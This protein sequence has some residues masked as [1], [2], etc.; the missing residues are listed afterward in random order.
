MPG[1]SNHHVLENCLWKAGKQDSITTQKHQ[2]DHSLH[3]VGTG[4]ESN[5]SSQ[6][7]KE[8]KTTINISMVEWG[9]AEVISAWGCSRSLLC[10]VGQEHSA[11]SVWAGRWVFT[12]NKRQLKV[13]P[14][15]WGDT[16]KA[17]S[18]QSSPSTAGAQCLVHKAGQPLT[19]LHNTSHSE[20]KLVGFTLHHLLQLKGR[21]VQK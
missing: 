12:P 14:S 18:R 2:S 17:L 3:K 20:C 11:W 6:M 9:A 7:P 13:F 15:L 8:G 10:S 19:V 21:T 5:S 1:K 4:T 16:S